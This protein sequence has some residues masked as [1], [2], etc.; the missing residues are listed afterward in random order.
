MQN[1]KLIIFYKKQYDKSLNLTLS[2]KLNYTY[3]K[4]LAKLSKL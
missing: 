1:D 3:N 4:K 2:L